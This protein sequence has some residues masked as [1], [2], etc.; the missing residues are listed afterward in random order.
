M[1]WEERISRGGGE[2]WVNGLVHWWVH[3]WLVMGRGG[4]SAPP[5]RTQQHA[6]RV[7]DG[8]LSSRTSHNTGV[9]RWLERGGEGDTARRAARLLQTL[10]PVMVAEQNV[11][12]QGYPW[13]NLDG[14]GWFVRY[15][16]TDC[17]RNGMR[18]RLIG[19]GAEAQRIAEIASDIV[20]LYMHGWRPRRGVVGAHAPISYKR[21]RYYELVDFYGFIELPARQA[22]DMGDL[23]DED[24]RPT[25]ALFDV[26]IDAA[27]GVAACW[28]GDIARA[29]EAL[30]YAA[31]AAPAA[32]QRT[33]S[34][35]ESVLVDPPSCALPRSPVSVAAT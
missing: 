28:D 10:P 13:E 14:R 32:S 7:T 29:A 35:R 9:R 24:D 18:S 22:L 34:P 19:Y 27:N 26:A 4:Y 33:Q 12:G 21:V 23:L 6:R 3:R 17:T 11:G 15:K 31:P 8:T 20:V 1:A 30:R 16:G 25:Q 2:W 5:R